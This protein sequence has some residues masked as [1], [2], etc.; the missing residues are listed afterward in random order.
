MTKP[1][2]KDGINPNLLRALDQDIH[3]ILYN[4]LV[5]FHTGEADYESWHRECYHSYQSQEQEEISLS[6]QKL[7]KNHTV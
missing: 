5:E 4:K 2:Q 1:L 3:I 7:K 6:P